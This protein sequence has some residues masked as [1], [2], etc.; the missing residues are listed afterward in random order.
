MPEEVAIIVNHFESTG[1]QHR[2]KG[3]WSICLG[4]QRREIYYP[5]VFPAT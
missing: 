3:Y 5:L 4:Q 1:Y 2:A